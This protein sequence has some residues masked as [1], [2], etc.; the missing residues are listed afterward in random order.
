MI[1]I[2]LMLQTVVWLLLLVLFM[3]SRSG[4]IYHPFLYYLVFHG[5]V[6]VIRPIEVYTLDFDFIFTAMAFYP[7]ESDFIFVLA[8]T[9]VGLFAFASTSW[10]RDNA[11]PKYVRQQPDGFNGLEW[12]AFII[13]LVILGPLALYSVYYNLSSVQL[14]ENSDVALINMQRDS[15][16]GVI[17]YT[18]TTGYI[19]DAQLFLAPISLMFLWGM[20]FRLFAF[21]PLM[22]YLTERAYIGWARW[23]II[24]TVASA[25]LLFAVRNKHRW[26]PSRL[27]FVA[28]PM[29]LIFHQLG[30]SRDFIKTLLKGDE[31]AISSTSESKSWAQRLDTPDFANFDFLTYVVNEVPERTRT[32][33]YFTQYL[34]LFTEPIPRILWS[35]KPYG[36]PVLLVNLNESGNFV[37][38]TVS[39]VGDGWISLGWLGVI[40]TMTL[41]G[42]ITSR[43]HRWFWRDQATS[44]KILTYCIFVP[45]TVQWYRDG[46]ITIAKFMFT[47]IGPIF[48]WK[49]VLSRLQRSAAQRERGFDL[50]PRPRL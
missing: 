8:L 46:G 29:F 17:G 42:Y 10:L 2:A 49:I 5:L 7:S 15:Q 35:S 47:A 20:R 30:E 11:F 38:W 12:R 13:V 32:Y 4:S 25:G 6:F 22:L 18:N 27:V 45:L 43:V 39:L 1:P 48:L 23:T 3:H 34:Q 26:I 28:I 31:S 44:F 40:A 16:T 41:V 50:F 24:L 9:T 14:F 37:G 21:V 36:P 33:S 19:V